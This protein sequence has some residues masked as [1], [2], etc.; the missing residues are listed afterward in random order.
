[1]DCKFVTK[2]ESGQTLAS[3]HNSLTTTKQHHQ[4]NHTQQ[5]A[6]ETNPRLWQHQPFAA[7]PSLP[8]DDFH[9]LENPNKYTEDERQLRIKLAAVYRLIELNGWAMGIYNHVTVS[10]HVFALRVGSHFCRARHFP[11][12]AIVKHSKLTRL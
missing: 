4:Y 8:I 1:M 6:F 12:T 10:V 11:E 9:L 5:G 7:P 3:N 2:A